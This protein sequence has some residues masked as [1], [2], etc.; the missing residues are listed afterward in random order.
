M[1][2]MGIDPGKTG[3]VCLLGE[4]ARPVFWDAPLLKTGKREVYDLERIRDWLRAR[5]LT[6]NSAHAFLEEP[7]PQPKFSASAN[8]RLGQ[9]S[10]IWEMALV[11]FEIPYTKVQPQRWKRVMMEGME[12]GKQASIVRAL[13]L[14]SGCGEQLRRVKDHGRADAL[15]IAEYGIRQLGLR[16]TAREELVCSP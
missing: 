8:Y 10:G 3:A 16:F 15:L 14:Y 4:V 11:S 12:K 7:N 9:S 1:I 5:T 13:M 6:G 2:V